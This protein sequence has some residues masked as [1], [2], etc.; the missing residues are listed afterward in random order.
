[1]QK[2]IEGLTGTIKFDNEGLRSDFALE[3]VELGVDG[4]VPIGIWEFSK[5]YTLKKNYEVK[6]LEEEP[7]DG[8]LSHKS[9][10]VITCLVCSK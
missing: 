1:M 6:K 10:V 4:L 8:R 9:F 7:D 5:G 2:S 3:V